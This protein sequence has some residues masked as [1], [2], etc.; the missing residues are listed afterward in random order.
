MI[1]FIYTISP[2]LIF[3]GISY[4][5]CQE[6]NRRENKFYELMDQGVHEGSELEKSCSLFFK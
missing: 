1:F 4:L 5:W 2:V 3:L 6:S